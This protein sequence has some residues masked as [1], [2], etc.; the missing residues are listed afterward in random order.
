[1]NKK[2][3]I[4]EDELIQAL[5]KMQNVG[6]EYPAE[7]LDKRRTQF[8]SAVSGFAISIPLI[9]LL[10][11]IWQKI[12]WHLILKIAVV[13]SVTAATIVGVYVLQKQISKWLP[14]TTPAI[15]TVQATVNNSTYSF[16]QTATNTPSMPPTTKPSFTPTPTRIR[17]TD[18]GKHLGQTQTPN[19]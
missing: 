5:A 4:Q 8:H 3:Q 12:A 15:S 9:L 2:T 6:P 13:S 10:K 7:S 16:T 18:R 17:P 1:M 14:V 11:N 19:P